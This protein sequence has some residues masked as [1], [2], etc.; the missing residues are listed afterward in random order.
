MTVLNCYYGD[1]SR[2]KK[3]KGQKGIWVFYSHRIQN[4]LLKLGGEKKQNK[5]MFISIWRG[6][7]CKLW[8]EWVDHSQVNIQKL[9]ISLDGNNRLLDLQ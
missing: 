1:C 6:S 2:H 9:H 4:W 3:I 8:A 7:D 5:N